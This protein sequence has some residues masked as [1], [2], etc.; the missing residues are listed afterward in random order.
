M[1][2][3]KILSNK[4]K[5]SKNY[6]LSQYRTCLKLVN[7]KKLDKLLLQLFVHDY[8][9]FTIVNDKGFVIVTK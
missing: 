2:A 5:K 1:P 8:Q 9:P 3:P 6:K 7:K 4:N